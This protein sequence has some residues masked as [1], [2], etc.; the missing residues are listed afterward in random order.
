MRKYVWPV[1]KKVEGIV[2]MEA[3]K[4]GVCNFIGLINYYR[5]I[6]TRRLY[7]LQP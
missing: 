7:M 2:N 3:K 5:E 6:W 4:M 1:T